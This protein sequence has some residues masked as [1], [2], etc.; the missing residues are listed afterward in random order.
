MLALAT[1][2]WCAPRSREGPALRCAPVWA[3]RA[4]PALR[5]PPRARAPGLMLPADGASTPL[6]VQSRSQRPLTPSLCARSG[7]PSRQGTP[8]WSTRAGEEKRPGRKRGPT[9]EGG[10]A[11]K[12]WPEPPSLSSEWHGTVP[13][14]D[15]TVYFVGPNR[16]GQ[17]LGDGETWVRRIQKALLHNFSHNSELREANSDH[18]LVSKLVGRTVWKCVFKARNGVPGRGFGRTS[19]PQTWREEDFAI[20]LPGLRGSEKPE[21]VLEF[22]NPRIRRR[23]RHGATWGFLACMWAKA[24]R[25]AESYPPYGT[26][27]P[28]QTPQ[29]RN[30]GLFRNAAMSL[31]PGNHKREVQHGPRTICATWGLRD[32]IEQMLNSIGGPKQWHSLALASTRR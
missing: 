22:R 27:W 15:G 29:S 13:T 10:V 5:R 2:C 16:S 7:G 32:R 25:H 23:K 3:G 30:S 1:P 26:P 6:A 28:P 8:L 11:P 19:V 9:S 4:P 24:A 21:K 14:C 31:E 20:A 18:V 12:T 17:Q